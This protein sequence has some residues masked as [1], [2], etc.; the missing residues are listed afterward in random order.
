MTI[1]IDAIYERRE[2]EIFFRYVL[3]SHQDQAVDLHLTFKS[4]STTNCMPVDMMEITL[5]VKH[6]RKGL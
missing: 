6:K 2:Q 1:L 4:L 3:V 5:F